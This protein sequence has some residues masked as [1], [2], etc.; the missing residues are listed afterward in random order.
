MNA[1]LLILFS[2]SIA[3]NCFG[4]VSPAEKKALIKLYHAT[5][6]NQWLT[7][8]DLKTPVKTWYGVKVENDHVVE[9][10]L[11]G[12][13]LKGSLPEAMG[14]LVY[15]QKL[16]LSFNTLTGIIPS[17]IGSLQYL[18]SLEFFLNKFEC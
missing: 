6:G 12:N 15:L 11:Q 1:K 2:L 3:F 8:W 13:N 10:N 14:D 16:N 17:T 9:L 7:T 4:Q 18:K 5:K